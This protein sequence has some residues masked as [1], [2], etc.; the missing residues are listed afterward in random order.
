MKK[1]LTIGACFSLAFLIL[2]VIKAWRLDDEGPHQNT[3]EYTERLRLAR[4]WDAYHEATQRRTGADLAEAIRLYRT[5]L[6]IREDHEESLYYL[7]TCLLEQGDY[8]DSTDTLRRLL[9]VNP[10]S[11]R[12]YSLLGLLHSSLDPG[13]HLDLPSA[14]EA[15]LKNAELDPEESGPFLRLGRIALIEGDLDEAFQ[16]FDKA[17]GFA[18]P[19]GHFWCGYVRFVQGNAREA[20][21]HF[22]K[23]LE[24]GRHEQAIS[25][26]GGRVE[27]D[28]QSSGT[29]S[30]LARAE[31]KARLFLA[32]VRAEY[33]RE[34]DLPETVHLPG[35]TRLVRIRLGDDPPAEA[36]AWGDFDGDGH[37]DLALAANKDLRIF[38]NS[39]GSDPQLQETARLSI[40]RLRNLQTVD[41]DGDGRDDLSLLE[42]TSEGLTLHRLMRSLPPQP[43]SADRFQFHDVSAETGLSGIGALHGLHFADFSGNGFPDL[44]ELGADGILYFRNDAGR[45]AS[46]IDGFHIDLKGTVIDATTADVDGDGHLDI[47]LTRWRRP[48]LLLLNDGSGRFRDA[49]EE[50]GLGGNRGDSYAALFTDFDR[51]GRPDLLVS[52]YAP[53]ESSIAWLTDPRIQVDADRPVL[54]LN[55]GGSFRAA[56]PEAGLNHPHGTF[57]LGSGDFDGDDWEDVVLVNGGIDPTRLEPSVLLLNRKGRGY[58][59][60][61]L[62]PGFRPA[63]SSGI[64][65]ADFDGDGRTDFYLFG[66]GLFKLRQ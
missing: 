47:Y 42:E 27:G 44:L 26:R 31:V 51:D 46:R 52:R 21:R 45:F 62:V 23:V 4:F 15:F 17:A 57:A 53:W 1:I 38:R 61:A 33:S 2:A 56:G 19:E 58:S 66:V 65:V 9:E 16:H 37:L 10:R 13:A 28:T 7:A 60:S 59:A 24:I 35:Q 20:E 50:A 14:R 32:W 40:S 64:A 8:A 18:S 34:N 54:L 41:Y 30:P 43:G 29:L 63:R 49:T 11:H 6:E 22:Q 5:A 25:G 39:G 3:V 48:G 12:G 55:Q 36:A